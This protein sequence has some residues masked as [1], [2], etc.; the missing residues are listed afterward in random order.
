MA[1]DEGSWLQSLGPAGRTVLKP[2]LIWSCRTEAGHSVLATTDEPPPARGPLRWLHLNLADQRSHRWIER[3]GLLPPAVLAL[4]LSPD[5]TPRVAGEGESIGLVLHD[6][7]RDFDRT[8]TGRIAALNIAL[9]PRL[10]LTGRYHP[11]HS[12]DVLRERI[13]R[14]APLA[15]ADDAMDLVLRTIAET[16]AE[17]IKAV[18]RTLLAAEDDLI[19]GDSAALDSGQLIRL[20][21]VCS[22]LHRIIAEMRGTLRDLAELPLA[23]AEVVASATRIGDRLGTLDGDVVAAHAQ[24]RLLR[25]ELDLR[26]AQKTN[27]N[28]YLLSILTA[29]TMPAT[30]VTGFFGMNTGCRSPARRMARSPRRSSRPRPRGEPICC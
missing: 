2:G 16:L 5:P 19:G 9:A 6:F 11:L 15:G 20:R 4:F 7:E 26:A 8:D 29:V 18:S 1:A 25:D 27:Q 3:E 13:A 14:G 22:R 28:L 17:R 23:S 21:R 10:L 24:L 12:P 30:L